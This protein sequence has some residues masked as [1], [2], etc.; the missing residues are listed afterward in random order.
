MIYRKLVASI[1]CHHCDTCASTET[2]AYQKKYKTATCVI[3]MIM[4]SSSKDICQRP[5]EKKK[6]IIMKIIKFVDNLE[7][8]TYIKNRRTVNLCTLCTFMFFVYPVSY[9]DSVRDNIKSSHSL[10]YSLLVLSISNRLSNAPRRY[11]CH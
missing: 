3:V 10:L 2:V 5:S 6:K 4:T 8:F 9:A 1:K 7:S 11:L